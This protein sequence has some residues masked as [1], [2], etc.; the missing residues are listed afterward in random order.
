MKLDKDE[1][2][3]IISPR[4]LEYLDLFAEQRLVSNGEGRRRV[5]AWVYKKGPHSG[6]SWVLGGLDMKGL[7]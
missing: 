5:T 2:D 3:S 7:V 4:M 6:A 1:Y